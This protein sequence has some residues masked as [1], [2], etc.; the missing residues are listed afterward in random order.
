M[1]HLKCNLFL[2]QCVMN[3][4]IKEYCCMIFQVL[5]L[6]SRTWCV[7]SVVMTAYCVSLHSLADNRIS[8][9]GCI[10]LFD[11]LNECQNLQVLK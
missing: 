11:A 10:K 1:T 5:Y 9:S 8:D 7:E 3:I 6:T 4:H 2:P